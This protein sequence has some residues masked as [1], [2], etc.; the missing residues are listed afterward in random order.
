[1]RPRQN[2]RHF[3]DDI[4]K[5]IF[6]DE[7]VWISIQVS[8]KFVP[9]GPINNITALVQIMAWRR[10]GD[11][12]LSEPM[13]IISMTHICVTRPQW[14]KGLHLGG[15]DIFFSFMTMISMTWGKTAVIPLL[16]HWSYHSVTLSH[17]YSSLSLV[18]WQH[19]NHLPRFF[20]SRA[21]LTIPFFLNVEEEPDGII[22]V[23]ARETI[24]ARTRLGPFEAPRTTQEFENESDL[25]V[26]KVINLQ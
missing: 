25:F 9:K 4:F 22:K 3:P 1:M 2:G 15:L 19:G 21:R 12:P 24:A 10:P 13:M 16:M 17:W 20:L 14:V 18:T 5:R 6:F 23:I 26:L 11:K 7:N 8:L